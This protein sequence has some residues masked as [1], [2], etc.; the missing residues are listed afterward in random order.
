MRKHTQQTPAYR[1]LIAISAIEQA[2]HILQNCMHDLGM[3]L[4]GVHEPDIAC[5]PLWFEV[6]RRIARLASHAKIVPLV[7][8]PRIGMNEAERR[9]A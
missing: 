1:L 3:A 8:A 2:D 9:F 5:D 4:R 6:E 7:Q